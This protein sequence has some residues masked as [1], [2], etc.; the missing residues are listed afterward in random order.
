MLKIQQPNLLVVLSIIEFF[1][2]FAF[3][4]TL[5]ILILFLVG[6]GLTDKV[7]YGVWKNFDALIYMF[8][9]IGGVFGGRY[10]SF[11]QSCL[12]GLILMFIGYLILSLNTHEALS[13]IEIGLAFAAFGTGIVSPNIRNLLGA[14]YQDRVKRYNGFTIFHLPDILAQ[15]LGPSV[16]TYIG[17]YSKTLMF[18]AAS[19]SVFLALITF[20]FFYKKLEFSTEKNRLKTISPNLNITYIIKIII[21]LTI[22]ALAIFVMRLED[23]GYILLIFGIGAI[24]YVIKIIF[25]SV[26]VD[27]IRII[28]LLLLM[29][30]FLVAEICFRQ[31][32]SILNL[33]TLEYVDKYLNNYII[34][35]GVFQS[36]EP[37]FVLMMAPLFLYLWK[38]LDKKDIKIT[39]GSLFSV[40][41]LL[42]TASFGSLLIGI[43][44]TQTGHQVHFIWLLF[45][46]GFMSCSELMILPIGIAAVVELS[47]ERWKEILM[48]CWLLLI[49]LASFIN[50]QVGQYIS[51]VIKEAPTL[52]TYQYVFSGMTIFAFVCGFLLYIV[53]KFWWKKYQFIIK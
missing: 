32:F 12:I 1:I 42:L 4:G 25:N 31:G 28:S 46:Y 49:S 41:L 48:G 2:G 3:F 11:K 13:L 53:W 14:I 52:L 5:A 44:T 50:G 16:L 20:I 18:S 33:F 47:P 7:S 19:I 23:V 34:P 40:G 22:L 15:I 10:F 37:F 43:L 24:I 17:L 51:H 6:T 21:F 26:Y 39:S 38:F 27:K 8:C 9:L 30:G 29:F 45:C 36:A 35:T